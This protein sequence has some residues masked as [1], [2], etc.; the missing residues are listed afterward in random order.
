MS[1]YLHHVF[2]WFACWARWACW[3]G[4]A[5]GAI[6]FGASETHAY[7]GRHSAEAVLTY[8]AEVDVPLAG[9]APVLAELNREGRRRAEALAGVDFQIQHLMGTFQS[10]SFRKDFGWPGVLGESYRVRFKKVAPGSASGR[11]R[12][13][14]EF[15]GTVVFQKE[16]FNGHPTRLLPVKLPLAPDRIYALSLVRGTSACT[17]RHYDS[18][19]DFWYFWDPDQRG[20]PLAGNDVDVMRLTGKLERLPNTRVAYPEYDRLY[21]DNGNG[22]A[23]EVAVFFGYIDDL[24]DLRNPR[25]RD[26][27]ARA[28]REVERELRARGFRLTGKAD[29]FREYADGR[30]VAGINFLR[31][32]ETRVVN[33]LGL[34]MPVRVQVLLADTAAAS[35]D[36][37]F[38]R[39]LVPALERADIVA[40]DGHSGLGGNLDLRTL[41][42]LRLD[43]RKYQIFYFNGC[44]SYPYFNEK[45]FEAKGGSRNLEI[46]LSGLPTF[47]A[48]A[49]PNVVAFL[50]QFLGGRTL[51]YQRILS[52]VEESNAEYGTYLTG[53]TG[54]QDNRWRPR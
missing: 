15:K 53:V 47:T 18:E 16:A 7:Y 40:Y 9:R 37:T 28:M 38:H 29:A 27:G 31:E 21:G 50:D 39:F 46:V 3:I 41:R 22:E 23:L 35:R 14:Y 6:S 34:E 36:A 32:Y 20:C 8:A 45:Y 42:G 24:A 33:E 26:D 12:L 17:D 2:I 51:S 30:R 54:E 13:G 44:S 48:T 4:S 25:R 52:S 11:V 43:P 19:D 49:G 10:E 5:V 1:S